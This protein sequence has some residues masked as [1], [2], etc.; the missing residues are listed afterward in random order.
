MQ[1]EYGVGWSEAGALLFEQHPFLNLYLY[2]SV[3]DFGGTHR[4]SG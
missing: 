1:R 4:G 2:S 3:D